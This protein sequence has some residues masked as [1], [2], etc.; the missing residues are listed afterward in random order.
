MPRPIPCLHPAPSFRSRSFKEFADTKT[1]WEAVVAMPPIQTEG[2]H[3][4]K[5]GALILRGYFD[6]GSK[7][8]VYALDFIPSEGEW[9]P[10]NLG[11]R[12]KPA[13]AK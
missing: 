6:A 9:K 4:D 3:I 11:V 13:G 12:V 1:D 7:H 10:V 5:R 8:V 2:S